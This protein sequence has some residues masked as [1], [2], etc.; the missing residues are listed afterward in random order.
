LLDELE[1]GSQV[2]E[3][4]RDEKLLKLFIIQVISVYLMEHLNQHISGLIQVYLGE[5]SKF[6]QHFLARIL[7][8]D[9]SSHLL[10]CNLIEQV[11]KHLLNI[12]IKLL[13]AYLPKDFHADGHHLVLVLHH[14]MVERTLM[15]SSHHIFVQNHNLLV[16]LHNLH[17]K[18]ELV[19][20]T[21]DFEDA[22]EYAQELRDGFGDVDRLAL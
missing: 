17:P 8:F 16:L 13:I 1:L 12:E 11:L 4:Q 7:G 22:L 3:P 21:H 19:L 14:D 20:D 15:V 6:L 10:E 5:N 9:L 2:R 18:L